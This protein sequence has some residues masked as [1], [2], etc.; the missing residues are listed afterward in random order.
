MLLAVVDVTI[1]VTRGVLERRRTTRILPSSLVCEGLR[2]VGTVP[3]PWLSGLRCGRGR[4]LLTPSMVVRVGRGRGL[5]GA[6]PL[7][8]GR[9]S[10]TLDNAR[11]W[12]SFFGKLKAFWRTQGVWLAVVVVPSSALT[13][14]GWMLD[15]AGE[16]SR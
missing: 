1:V 9:T 10:K 13:S 11:V 16:S 14:S 4:A 5:T 3:I 6:A 15:H 12:S 7:K 2:L 8:L